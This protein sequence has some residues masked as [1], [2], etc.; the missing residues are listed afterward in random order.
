MYYIC[1]L[2]DDG[3]WQGLRST[4]DQDYSEQLC[5]YFCD[6]Y[7]SAYNDILTHEEFHSKELQQA[8]VIN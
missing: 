7:S 3:N 8:M 1:R 5:D 6:L 2:Q 4:H